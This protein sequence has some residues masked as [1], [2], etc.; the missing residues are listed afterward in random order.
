M[1]NSTSVNVSHTANIKI[2]K[3]AQQQVLEMRKEHKQGFIVPCKIDDDVWKGLFYEL[4]F[5]NKYMETRANCSAIKFEGGQPK[6][7][8]D[9]SWATREQNEKWEA[10]HEA[11]VKKIIS[12]Q[13]VE[14]LQVKI[15]DKTGQALV[16]V[17]WAN[18][19][20]A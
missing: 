7:Y 1:F 10:N 12:E 19:P 5:L 17:R 20:A 6:Y 8:E 16:E 3:E 11:R 15:L 18:N 2:K 14:V 4:P 9:C 13:A